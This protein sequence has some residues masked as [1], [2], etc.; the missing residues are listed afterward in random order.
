MPGT[1]AHNFCTILSVSRPHNLTATPSEDSPALSHYPTVPASTTAISASYP[2]H[3]PGTDADGFCNTLSLTEGS[4][5]LSLCPTVPASPT[6]TSYLTA[7]AW[8]P[9][10]RFLY[11]TLRFQPTQSYCCPLR[12]LTCLKPLPYC[13]GFPQFYFCLCL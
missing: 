1:H 2:T 12:G 5:T 7:H 11:H 10:T 6:A 4:P 8:N 9:R 3:M 13:A